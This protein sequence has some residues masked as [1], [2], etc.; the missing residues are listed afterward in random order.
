VSSPSSRALSDFCGASRDSIVSRMIVSQ[1][2][3]MLDRLFAQ[4]VPAGYHSSEAE[5]RR[6][7][8]EQRPMA[9]QDARWY[10]AHASLAECITKWPAEAAS[11]DT[12]EATG[13]EVSI[14]GPPDPT[15]VRATDELLAAAT[16]E[17]KG[18]YGGTVY[19]LGA[20]VVRVIRPA[21]EPPAALDDAKFKR[22]RAVISNPGQQFDDV[23]KAIELLA[24][25]R[26][27]RVIDAFLASGSF[28]ALDLLSQWGIQRAAAP[29]DA[30]IAKLEQSQDRMIARVRLAR[31]RLDA[32]NVASRIP[33][34]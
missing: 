10:A 21:A 6:H 26:S 18:H 8:T 22:L 16:A 33:A 19:R 7:G 34:P 27:E 28:Y 23:T 1:L 12:V 29:L 24:K 30:L 2:A 15:L 9:P 5:A 3:Q 4:A 17:K 25:E 20:T 13:L 14:H 31:H 32:W 11:M